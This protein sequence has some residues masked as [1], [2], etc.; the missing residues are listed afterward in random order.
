MRGWAYGLGVLMI[1]LSGCSV[2]VEVG[3]DDSYAAPLAEPE[4]SR[5][6]PLKESDCISQSG[7]S[8]H[9]V[10][11]TAPE[12]QARV[13][14][15]SQA[16][17]NQRFMS[18]PDCPPRTDLA[19][20]QPGTSSLGYFCARNL[21]PPHPGDPGMGGGTIDVG[22]CLHTEGAAIDEVPCDG[23]G[24]KPQYKIRQITSTPCPKDRANVSF[25]LGSTA[26][27]GIPEGGFACAQKL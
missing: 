26:V 19:L 20:S 14:K 2:G 13:T 9:E 18:R 22:D 1:L 21:K 6:G 27:P 15:V 25:S 8:W 3:R 23:S 4:Y 17:G 12:A 7:G 10:P 16:Q 5:P 24:D 11:C